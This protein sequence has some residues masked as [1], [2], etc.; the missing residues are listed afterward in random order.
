MIWDINR[1][2][3]SAYNKMRDPDYQLLSAYMS[4]QTVGKIESKQKPQIIYE[5]RQVFQKVY[6][7]IYCLKWT[8]NSASELVYGTERYLR[9]YDTREHMNRNFQSEDINQVLGLSFDPF[10]NRRLACY[11]NDSIRV[12]DLRSFQKPI[13]TLRD[14]ERFQN[15]L[16][17]PQGVEW[18]QVRRDTLFSFSRRSVSV[19]FLLTF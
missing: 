13:Y 10:D 9:V 16:Y 11:N 7:D 6:D 3:S 17:Q 18:S 4:E 19:I 12:F 2:M 15:D 1:T 14:E 5:P 8:P